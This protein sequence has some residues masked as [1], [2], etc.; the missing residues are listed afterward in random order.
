MSLTLETIREHC[1][2]KHKNVT[3]EF[4]F[5]E[6][7]LVFKIHN[8][9]FLLTRLERHPLS[10]NLKCDPESAIE[11]REKYEAVQPGYHMNKKYWNTIVIDGSIPSRQVLQM[12]DHSYEQVV[13]GL[14]HS[15][16][17]KLETT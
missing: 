13:E 3:E 15:L 14:P 17:K 10:I 16:R 9:I 2:H 8:K 5:G 6:D 7:V 1:L 4:P 12:I 11:L